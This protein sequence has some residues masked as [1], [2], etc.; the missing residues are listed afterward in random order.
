[1]FF[2]DARSERHG[3]HGD[4]NAHRVI[5][6]AHRTIET[7]RQLGNREQVRF[8]RRRRVGA[9]TLQQRNLLRSRSARRFDRFRDFVLARHA[10]RHYQRL[11]GASHLLDQADVHQLKRRHFMRRNIHPF[12]K[13][14][15]RIVERTRKQ[16][17]SEFV[18]DVFQLRLPFPGRKRLLVEV[19]E[20]LAIPQRAPG[21]PKT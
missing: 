18:R 3:G 4:R 9:R 2:N 17:H 13:I 5:R 8:V 11:P 6:K 7:A 10:R 19:V 20:G 15:G 21:N 1:M 12:E 16:V 14:D